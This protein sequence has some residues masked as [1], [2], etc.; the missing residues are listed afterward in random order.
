MIHSE[1]FPGCFLCADKLI[2]QATNGNSGERKIEVEV[3]FL[4]NEGGGN[5][6]VVR[7]NGRGMDKG[8]LEAFATYHLSQVGEHPVPIVLSQ[9]VLYGILFLLKL[10]YNINDPQSYFMPT[11]AGLRP[12]RTMHDRGSPGSIQCLYMRAQR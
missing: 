11:Q 1:L 2:L 9:N 3:R 6:M 7:D 10:Y 5:Y 8:G 12:T 4:R